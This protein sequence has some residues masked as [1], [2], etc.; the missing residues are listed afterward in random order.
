MEQAGIALTEQFYDWEQRGRGW[1]L[2]PEQVDIEPPFHPFFGHVV[3]RTY[4]DDGKRST[5]LS[6]LADVFRGTPATPT[7]APAVFPDIELIP[8]KASSLLRTAQVSFPKGVQ[9]KPDRL[10]Q[11][12]VMLTRC[13][14]HLSFEIIATSTAIT[15]Q[16]VSR[17][18]DY[19]YF[20][21]QLE[22]F[23]PECIVSDQDDALTPTDGVVALVDFGLSE[24]FMRPIA[25]YTGS[26]SDPFISLFGVLEHLNHGEQVVLQVLFSGVVNAWTES[27]RRS[28]SDGQAGSFF[29]NAPEMPRLADEKTARPLFGVCLRLCT[30]ATHMDR[31]GALLRTVAQVLIT[32]TASSYNSFMGLSDAEYTAND[33]L[34]DMFERQTHRLGMLLNIRELMSLV[35]FPSPQ[36]RS[37]KLARAEMATKAPPERAAFGD[38][39]LG[40]NRHRNIHQFVCLS[41]QERLQHIHIIGAT[42]TGKSTLLSSLIYG[43]IA[44]GNGIAVVDPHGDLID[45]VLSFIPES[46]I[47]DVVLIDP[48]DTDYAVG[49]NILHAHTPLEQELLSSDLVALFRRFSTSWGDQMNSVFANAIIAILASKEGGTLIDL[50]RFLIEK[51]FRD[52]VLAS[53]TDQSILYYWQHEYPL[54][55]SSSLGSILTRLDTFLRPRII[56]A[57]VSQRK[58]L[59]FDLLMDEKKIVLVKLAQGLIGTENSFILGASII[60][61]F[62]Q[63]AMARQSKERSTRTPYYIYIDEFHHFATPT[64]E[65]ILNGARKYGLGLVVAHQNMQQLAGDTSLASALTANAGTRICFRL[66]DTDAKRFAEGFTDF[67]A[68]HLQNL[69]VGEAIARIGRAEDDF[70]LSVIDIPIDDRFSNQEAIIMHSRACYATPIETLTTTV[71]PQTPVESHTPKPTQPL[72]PIAPQSTNDIVEQLVEREQVRKHRYLQTLIKKMAEERGYKAQLEIPILEGSGKVDVSLLREDER[73]AVEISVTTSTEWE[74]HNIQKCLQAGYHTVCWCTTDK[75]ALQ[76]MRSAISTF[77]SVSQ[78]NQIIIAEPEFLF[79]LLEPI[80]PEPPAHTIKGYRVTVAYDQVSAMEQTQK[81]ATVAAIIRN[82]IKK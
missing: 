66:G 18:T 30:Q 58:S 9:P 63:A 19:P 82:T 16:L 10:E 75:T 12:L 3:P 37:R 33:R 13:S 71:V 70:S 11:L 55:K 46:R 20:R 67:T 76:K 81:R 69:A 60:A 22:A 31:A 15:I 39:V 40:I 41:E 72:E 5:W 27:I 77:F 74:L 80:S 25:T 4:I 50:R 62:Q 53:V 17:E 45:T 49:F 42:G 68:E 8:T 78:Q 14:Y 2:A 1:L 21:S 34:L 51:P 65:S 35:H 48:S 79:E 28:V 6:D 47:N 73:I 57:M 36:I 54:L 26:E 59:N 52:T 7:I 32:G 43:D 64:M 23:F 56:R 38:Y 29:V 24:E 61:K 44:Q